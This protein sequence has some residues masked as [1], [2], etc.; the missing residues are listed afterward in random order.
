MNAARIYCDKNPPRVQ[1]RVDTGS[2]CSL[3]RAEVA[4]TYGEGDIKTYSQLEYF[5]SYSASRKLP[6]LIP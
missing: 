2:T 4:Y 1:S 5:S 3:L 6:M